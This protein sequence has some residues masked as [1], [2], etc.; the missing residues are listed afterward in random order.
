LEVRLSHPAHDP[1]LVTSFR[2]DLQAALE[3]HYAI[4]RE[5]GGG[6]MSRVF[7]AEERRFARRVV[8]KVLAPD[9]AAALNA[10]RFDREIRVAA[11]L[12][13]PHIV[14]VINSGMAAGASYYT[15]PFVDGDSL[16]ARMRSA[17]ATS[18]VDLTEAIGILRDV[19]TA[20]EYAHAHGIVHRDIK[21]ENVLLSGRT[22]VVTDFGI[23]KALSASTTNADSTA[24][25]RTGVSLGTPAYV[26]PEQAAGDAADHRADIYAWGVMAYE[27]L[28]GAHPFAD[29]TSA[30]QLI[31]A[32]IAEQPAPLA[33]AGGVP[34]DLAAL[35]MRCL[36][37]NPG[38]R[39]QSAGDVLRVIDEVSTGARG[40]VRRSGLRAPWLT[41]A[42][43][44]ALLLIVGVVASWRQLG[45]ALSQRHAARASGFDG[46][47]FRTVA[48]LPFDNASGN[49]QDRYFADGLTDELA[50][51]LSHLPA[52]R[53]AARTSSYAFRARKASVVDI[54]RALHVGAVIEGSVQ[55][56]GERLRVTAQLTGTTDGLVLW[57]DKYESR[58]TDLFDV[59]DQVT[60]SIVAALMPSL[61]DTASAT[62][63]LARSSRGTS[64]QDAYD[65]Y[66]KGR[67]FMNQRSSDGLDRA[68]GLFRQAI[69]IDSGYAHAY[70]GLA[71]AQ[72]LQAAFGFVA[73][74]VAYARARPDAR[75]ALA[76]DSALAEPHISLGFI[77]LFFDLDL[78][79]AR[80]DLGAAIRLDP[81]NATAHL[82]NSW[83]ELAAMGAPAAIDEIGVAQRLD[84][85]SLIIDTRV[86]TMLR[87]AH[88]LDE[89]ERQFRTTLDLDSGFAIAHDELARLR[90]E[91]G[92]FPGAVASARRAVASGF[93]DGRATLGYSLARSGNR[94]EALAIIDELRRESATRY[95]PPSDMGLIY[96]GLG[97]IPHAIEW[98]SRCIDVRDHEMS[99][100]KIEPLLEPLRADARFQTLIARLR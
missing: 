12:Q 1:A 70:A 92:D 100:L 86:G 8:I 39:P 6:G 55:R 13:E 31:A 58:A 91:R 17:T 83:Y 29:C 56:S 38:S 18:P 62:L 27:L 28:S 95:V 19:A 66:L 76:L 7:L 41:Y 81:R 9:L 33:R 68:V 53:V 23:A 71:E 73:P 64:S 57:S 43:G 88:R 90:A 61:G 59:Q 44:A 4:E 82:Y 15:M 67:F 26:A 93:A 16:R 97:D 14:P 35:V 22:A 79:R 40:A 94:A 52:L 51:A 48:V 10:E 80:D 11:T 69:S 96:V 77:E 2:D 54:G 45:S 85:L 32:H 36:E 46:A 50:L 34:A 65:R 98:Y 87:Y 78:P 60:R 63:T 75:H 42:A 47:T 84:P 5:L 21:P 89:A 3:D 24:L 74:K 99:T 72:A 49:E 30:Q 25:T 37:K 20:L